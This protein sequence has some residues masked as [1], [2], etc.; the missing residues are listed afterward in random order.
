MVETRPKRKGG[1]LLLLGT[2]ALSSQIYKV[3]FEHLRTVEVVIL[4]MSL[5]LIGI[6]IYSLI[7][8][9]KNKETN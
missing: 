4:S 9:G 7:K 3:N 6:G 8:S 2:I 5:V 1:P